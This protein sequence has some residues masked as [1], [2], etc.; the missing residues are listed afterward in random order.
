VRNIL[1][2]LLL[3]M[4]GSPAFAVDQTQATCYYNANGNYSGGDYGNQSQSS[5]GIGQ[6][7]RLSYEGR[8][9]FEGD[10]AFVYI[11]ELRNEQFACPERLT[12][13]C[14]DCPPG[15]PIWKS[16]AQI[17]PP[18][19][20][21]SGKRPVRQS[22][23]PVT[24]KL[25]LQSGIQPGANGRNRI[26]VSRSDSAYTV[27]K[28][29]ISPAIYLYVTFANGS[30]IGPH[31]YQRKFADNVIFDDASGDPRDL[32]KVSYFDVDRN[33]PQLGKFAGQLKATGNGVGTVYLKVSFRNAPGVTASVP[34]EIVSG[35]QSQQ[36]T[37]V[38]PTQQQKQQQQLA[39]QRQRQQRNAASSRQEIAG[40]DGDCSESVR[41]CY[42]ACNHVVRRAGGTEY[43]GSYETAPC[44][45]GCEVQFNPKNDVAGHHALCTGLSQDT[46]TPGD[47]SDDIRRCYNSCYQQVNAAGGTAHTGSYET[48][49]CKVACETQFNPK[50]DIPGFHAMC[51]GL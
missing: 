27:E 29:L 3:S 34:V 17:T 24:A 4:T 47:C 48:S 44:K 13:S 50:G 31:D 28:L 26:P 10:Y 39:L 7:E 6:S 22:A 49:P 42:N 23:A 18:P 30:K 1:I 46:H 8:P 35:A 12:V 45:A 11:V 43:T 36:A 40:G 21:A 51:T 15:A 20:Q 32:I 16:S 38:Q 37:Q 25:S 14:S 2:F 19:N 5:L 9:V 33:N 41:R